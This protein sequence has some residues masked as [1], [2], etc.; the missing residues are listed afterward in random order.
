M[1]KVQVCR[2]QKHKMFIDSDQSTVL[3]KLRKQKK[4]GEKKAK[5]VFEAS[6]QFSLNLYLFLKKQNPSVLRH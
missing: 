4:K 1:H 5:Q 3:G 2:A 6:Q